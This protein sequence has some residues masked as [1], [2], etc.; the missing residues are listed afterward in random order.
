MNFHEKTSEKHEI[1][2]NIN[3]HASLT[4]VFRVRNLNLKGWTRLFWTLACW[5]WHLF[6][7]FCWVSSIKQLKEKL[8]LLLKEITIKNGKFS[9]KFSFFDSIDLFL[10]TSAEIIIRV[11]Q[12]DFQAFFKWPSMTS[13]DLKWPLRWISN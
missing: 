7:A 4:Y 3:S 12:V 6:F 11:N 1:F 10:E 5:C 2:Y 8:K 13:S 9:S